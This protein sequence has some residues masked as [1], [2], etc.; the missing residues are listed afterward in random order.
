MAYHT[1]NIC[2]FIGSFAVMTMLTKN[3]FIDEINKLYTVTARAKGLVK[4]QSF[5]FSCFKN[6]I[7]PILTGFPAQFVSA[8]FTGSILI[9]TIFSLDGIGLLSYEAIIQRDYPVVMGTL[10]IF[11]LL[12]LITKLIT[13]IMYVYVDPRIKFTSSDT[14]RNL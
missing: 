3:S 11:T 8:F 12:G 10:F 7:I 14:Q 1:S 6:A 9:E 13:D 4:K 2:L 5:I